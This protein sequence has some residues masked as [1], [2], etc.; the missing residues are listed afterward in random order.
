MIDGTQ[1]RLRGWQESDLEV[2][3]EMRNDLALQA[4]LLS[5]ARG[6]NTQQV[7]QWLQ[8]RTADAHRL[9]LIVAGREDDRTLGYLQL[10]EIDGIDQRAEL[11]ICICAQAQ[12]HGIGREVLTLVQPYLRQVWALRKL[13]LRVRSD[14]APAIACY[15]R[16]GFERC[17]LLRR[18]VHIDGKFHD[19][20]LM[21]L[22]LSGEGEPCV[23]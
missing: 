14:N 16:V 12:G 6:S 18:H 10:S 13:S 9:L 11:G 15:E 5:R 3:T 1:V 23:S 7:R 17:G 8:E 22:F 19:V 20:V 2:L 4:Q 21:E